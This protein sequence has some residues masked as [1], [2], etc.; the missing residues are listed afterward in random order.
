[1]PHAWQLLFN[2]CLLVIINTLFPDRNAGTRWEE[3]T[4]LWDQSL[5]QHVNRT[6][7][8]YKTENVIH[9]QERQTRRKRQRWILGHEIIEDLPFFVLFF[10]YFLH[11]PAMHISLF[12]SG[13]C[14]VRDERGVV[15]WIWACGEDVPEEVIWAGL[16]GWENLEEWGR[17]DKRSLWCSFF[18]CLSPSLGLWAPWRAH[19]LWSNL[20]TAASLASKTIFQKQ[21][22]T[23]A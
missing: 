1:M 9:T 5:K 22:K 8:V 15:T 16:E 11:F 13:G 4:L 14:S 20:L 3:N 18:F 12:Q 23:S 17:R 2:K 7:Y 19:C 6:H 10:M 21:T